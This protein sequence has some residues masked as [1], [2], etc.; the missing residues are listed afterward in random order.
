MSDTAPLTDDTADE[1]LRVYMAD[2]Q[3]IEVHTSLE[4][5]NDPDGTYR[6]ALAAD[7]HAAVLAYFRRCGVPLSVRRV[8]PMMDTRKG[9]H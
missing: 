6:A 2:D 7:I 3:R 5:E 9:E 1:V 8:Y 4:H